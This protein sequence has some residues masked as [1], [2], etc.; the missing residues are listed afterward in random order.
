MNQRS[1]KPARVL[2]TRMLCSMFARLS[3]TVDN[4][5]LLADMRKAKL[6]LLNSCTLM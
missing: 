1:P 3:M 5:S 6:S 4:K 2:G